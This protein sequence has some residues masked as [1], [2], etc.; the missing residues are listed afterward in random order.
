MSGRGHADT[1]TLTIDRDTRRPLT[2]GDTPLHMLLA[3][4]NENTLHTSDSL[5]I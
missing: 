5:L 1:C 4:L 3:L 2:H